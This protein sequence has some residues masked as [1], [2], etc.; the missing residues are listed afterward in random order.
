MEINPIIPDLS[1]DTIGAEPANLS[2]ISA[3]LDANLVAFTDWACRVEENLRRHLFELEVLAN[4]RMKTLQCV[5]NELSELKMQVKLKDDS[6]Q[7]VDI[8][9][10]DAKTTISELLEQIAQF[11]KE[12][13]DQNAKLHDLE[14]EIG[15]AGVRSTE[16]ESAKDRELIRKDEQAI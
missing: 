11:E 4:G 6:L 3:E 9:L 10:N 8:R 14:E 2:K 7:D 16:K 13:H 12:Q 15:A 1:S 5:R